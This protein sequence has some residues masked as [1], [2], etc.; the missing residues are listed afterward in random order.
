MSPFTI[1]RYSYGSNAAKQIFRRGATMIIGL[2]NK[3]SVHAVQ[4]TKQ[5]LHLRKHAHKADAIFQLRDVSL[6]T[7]PM[8]TPSNDIQHTAFTQAPSGALWY[9]Q[10]AHWVSH[11]SGR[12]QNPYEDYQSHGQMVKRCLPQLHTHPAQDTEKP[13]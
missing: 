10:P 8:A 6:L 1:A 5:F 11:C 7:R 2:S 13:N 4:I 3:T 9:P 12:S